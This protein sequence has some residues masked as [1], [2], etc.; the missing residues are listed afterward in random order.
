MAY[1]PDN[2]VGSTSPKDLM[3]NAENTDLL[4]LGDQPSYPDR[5]GVPR[6]SWRGME[7]EHSADQLRRTTDF[8][9]DQTE[10]AA[11]FKDFMDASG[12]E[13]PVP[14]VPG[15]ILSRSTQTVTY[16]G[17]EYRAKSQFLPLLTTS[18]STDE[19]KLKLVGD[20]SLRQE[21][22]SIVD[23]SKGAGQLGNN[24]ITL[25][26]VADL[27]AM[28]GWKLGQRVRTLGYYVVGDG[29]SNEY[30]V[31][32]ADTGVP[33]GGSYINI[34]GFQAKALFPSGSTNS[35]QF[36]SRGDLATDGQEVPIQAALDVLLSDST[37]Y[38]YGAKVRLKLGAHMLSRGIKFLGDRLLQGFGGSNATKLV[39]STA[40]D[41]ADSA[42][43]HVQGSFSIIE[44]LG[45]R[46]PPERYN[47]S[48]NAGNPTDG[49]AVDY[50]G[51]FGNTFRDFRVNGGRY[52]I[53]AQTGLESKFHNFFII[54]SKVGARVSAWDTELNNGIIQD[55]TQYGVDADGR[56]IESDKLHIVRAPILL[57]LINNGAPVNMT[58]TYLDTPGRIA[59]R[60][61]DQ[62][63]A[64][65]TNT[66]VSKI[67]DGKNPD[68]VAF[69]F[70]NGS[71]NNALM[72][73]NVVN[74][75]SNFSGVFQ[76]G[77]DCINNFVSG[78]RIP[79]KAAAYGDPSGMRGQTFVG[80]T[81]DGAR[82]NNIP[83]KNRGEAKG[84]APGSTAQI[85]LVLDYD[86]PT[87]SFN[88]LLLFGKWVSR[89]ASGQAAFGDINIPLQ[90][91]DY[92][93]SIVLTKLSGHANNSW[94][95]NSAILAGTQLIVTVQ[96]NGSSVSDISIELE[97]SLDAKGVTF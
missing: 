61:G 76:F 41:N 57:N 37:A 31:V 47:P 60:F 63:G 91:G 48:T 49:I 75:S 13:A 90:Y 50:A 33:D 18:W 35:K 4:A 53:H 11:Q 9:A 79:I 87:L 17:G 2:P 3:A 15:L 10:R 82:Y 58:N 5:K 24:I 74:P 97:R 21:L 44:N 64:L 23:A 25:G 89:N 55:C 86:Y 16:A 67:G 40:F 43:I 68:S 28:G 85:V 56:G 59:A 66:Y 71:N 73:G 19:P 8:L 42:L 54:G 30:V 52:G 29:G 88:T 6:K 83:R 95:I 65:M 81:G 46:V 72:G 22:A 32:A 14:Y 78:W 84:V 34:P 36:G 96:N 39:A 38:A 51:A 92:G 80:C 45:L 69:K 93:C 70:E 26:T 12:Y 7:N 27:I 77:S 62:R 20:D 1:S 94:A